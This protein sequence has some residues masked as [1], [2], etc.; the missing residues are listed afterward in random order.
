MRVMALDV[1]E[2]RI[3][4]AVSDALGI[5]AQGVQTLE[6]KSDDQ[7]IRDLQALAE[8]YEAGAWVIGLPKN[9]NNTLG[10]KSE[11]TQRFAEALT[12]ACPLPVY[13]MDERLTTVA[14]TQVLLQADVSRKKRKKKVDQLAAVLILQTWMDSPVGQE[15]CRG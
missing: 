13:W 10:Y 1:G 8:N 15:V 11:E 7:A 5:T 4:V 2:R 12:Q 6:R 3:G 9:M 14:A